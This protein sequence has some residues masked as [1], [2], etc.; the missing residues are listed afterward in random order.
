LYQNVNVC[1]KRKIQTKKEPLIT[2]VV[3]VH[4]TDGAIKSMENHKHTNEIKGKF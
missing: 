4:N 3:T 1:D 2:D